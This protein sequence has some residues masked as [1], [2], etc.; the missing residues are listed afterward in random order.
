MTGGS[1][2]LGNLHLW[3]LM[4]ISIQITQGKRER[5]FKVQTM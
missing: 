2:I 1:P 4:V 3:S 5:L